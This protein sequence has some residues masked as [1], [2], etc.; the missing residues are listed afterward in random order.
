MIRL[1]VFLL[2]GYAYGVCALSAVAY[3]VY[4]G[5]DWVINHY[6]HQPPKEAL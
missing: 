5:I 2:A 6:H 3:P 1:A 4:V